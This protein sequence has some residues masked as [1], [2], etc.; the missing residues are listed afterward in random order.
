MCTYPE[1]TAV[2][3]TAASRRPARSNRLTAAAIALPL[4]LGAV[5]SGCSAGQITQT[6]EK[7]PAVEGAQGETG[8][9]KVLNAHFV[10]PGDEGKYESGDSVE[11]ELV[12]T[13]QG[14]ADEITGIQVDG[15]DAQVTPSG[16]IEVPA[17]GMVVIGENGEFT[18]E[19]EMTDE[20]YPS[21][22]IPVVITFQEA[23]ELAMSVP[24]AASLDEIDR[25]PDQVYTP[26]EGEGGGH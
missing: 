4:A 8:D 9:L 21:T 24:I 14:A 19:A 11:L 16:S 5:L 20:A 23:G 26:E 10:A 1:E 2:S 13:S 25:D 15:A 12:V 6:A 18:V 7:R 22:L 17:G 3:L